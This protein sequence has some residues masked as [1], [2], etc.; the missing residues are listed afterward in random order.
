M[1]GGKQ[2]LEARPGAVGFLGLLVQAP[3][4]LR[5]PLTLGP[6]TPRWSVALSAATFLR[7][8]TDLCS[9]LSEA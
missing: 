7:P 3:I 9:S 5:E 8:R 1:G 6:P 4:G 2:A